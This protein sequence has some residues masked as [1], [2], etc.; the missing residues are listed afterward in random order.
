MNCFQPF[1]EMQEKDK[2]YKFSNRLDDVY[3]SNKSQLL[4]QKLFP[5]LD[6][7]YNAIVVEKAQRF[8][9]GT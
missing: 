4:I 5:P 9:D 1:M 2:G 7:A 3:S 6:E 8:K